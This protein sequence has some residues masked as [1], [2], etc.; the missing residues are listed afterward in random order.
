M[1][2]SNFTDK[3]AGISENTASVGFDG[4]KGMSGAKDF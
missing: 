2:H 1:S 3:Y 4:L